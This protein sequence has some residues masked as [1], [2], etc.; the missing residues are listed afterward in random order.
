MTIVNQRELLGLMTSNVGHAMSPLHGMPMT[1][2]RRGS[3]YNTAMLFMIV[4]IMLTLV[5]GLLGYFKLQ[6]AHDFVHGV[7][8]GADEP[9]RDPKTSLKPRLAERDNLRE[10][11][12]TLRDNIAQRHEILHELRLELADQGAYRDPNTGVWL[13]G[14]SQTEERLWAVTRMG[15]TN[16]RQRLETWLTDFYQ[17]QGMHE[18]PWF[19]GVRDLL[20]SGRLSLRREAWDMDSTQRGAYSVENSWRQRCAGCDHRHGRPGP[21]R[22]GRP[23]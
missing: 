3:A 1:P 19:D 15:V 23:A 9:I 2:A 4:L 6:D 16:T 7:E 11:I 20:E 22:R 8:G 12:D 5:F 21:T 10:R 18:Y 17:H 14:D 13:T